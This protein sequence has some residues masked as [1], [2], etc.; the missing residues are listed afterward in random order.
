[1]GCEVFFAAARQIVDG[2]H[3]EARSTSTSTMWLPM[4]PA[5]PVTIAIGRPVHAAL[6]DFRRRTLK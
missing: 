3:R 6:R 4:N 5:P 2:P 1:V